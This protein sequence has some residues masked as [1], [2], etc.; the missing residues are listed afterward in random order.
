MSQSKAT[1][2]TID[3]RTARLLGSL[4]RSRPVDPGELVAIGGIEPELFRAF[5]REA[6]YENDPIATQI[7]RAAESASDES[8][9]SHARQAVFKRDSSDRVRLAAATEVAVATMAR[10]EFGREEEVAVVG[11]EEDQVASLW[12][13]LIPNI[14]VR[15]E[16]GREVVAAKED[17]ISY[18][19]TLFVGLGGTGAK[20][21]DALKTLFQQR[22]LRDLFFGFRVFDSDTNERDRMK[23]VDPISE[24]GLLQLPAVDEYIRS[25]RSVLKDWWDFSYTVPGGLDQGAMAVRPN[26][27]LCLFHNARNVVFNHLVTAATTIWSP[28]AGEAV[29]LKAQ[30]IVY[31]I[32]SLCGGMG[33][34]TFLDTALLVQEA[35]LQVTNRKPQ[36][37]GVF[38]LNDFYE[39][40]LAPRHWPALKRNTYAAL[41]ELEYFMLPSCPHVMEEQTIDY[42]GVEVQCRRPFDLIYLIQATSLGGVSITRMDQ[43]AYMLADGIFLHLATPLG[44]GQRS[45]FVNHARTRVVEWYRNKPC[46]F[47]SMG[48]GSLA[49][50]QAQI[51][52]YATCL[53]LKARSRLLMGEAK[54]TVKTDQRA[55]KLLEE[56]EITHA[57]IKDK[58]RKSPSGVPYAVDVA[59]SL[60]AQLGSAG[61]RKDWPQVIVSFEHGL[62]NVHAGL[63][64]QMA[65]QAEALQAAVIAKVKGETNAMFRKAEGAGAICRYLE[66][67]DHEDDGDE[68]IIA[69]Q[70]NVAESELETLTRRTREIMADIG[71][72]VKSWFG[73]RFKLPDLVEGYKSAVQDRVNKRIEVDY[74]AACRDFY[75]SFDRE[76][77]ELRNLLERTLL[78][79]LERI[80]SKAGKELKHCQAQLT[81]FEQIHPKRTNRTHVQL[82][83]PFGRLEKS[84]AEVVRAKATSEVTVAAFANQ[85][86]DIWAIADCSGVAERLMADAKQIGAEVV[87]PSAVEALRA[88]AAGPHACQD[89]IR[90][91]C[92]SVCPQWAYRVGEFND[93]HELTSI[94]VGKG[95]EELIGTYPVQPQVATTGNLSAIEVLKTEH[96]LPLC[97]LDGIDIMHREYDGVMNERMKKKGPIGVREPVHLFGDKAAQWGEPAVAVAEEDDEAILLFALGNAFSQMFPPT[98]EERKYLKESWRKNCIY[99]NQALHFLQPF[100]AETDISP[101][102]VKDPVILGNSRIKSY[103][104][105]ADKREYQDE[106]RKYWNERVARKDSHQVR[107]LLG[108]YLMGLK[109]HVGRAH[110]DE[111][112]DLLKKEFDRVAFYHESLQ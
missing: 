24:F 48:V 106:I 25:H 99:S 107:E 90:E 76:L 3:E 60:D 74:L 29:A 82:I 85:I 111:L 9:D 79:P 11:R 15:D 44:A 81:D 33:G 91:F 68:E 45:S 36:V 31:I 57:A 101:R 20:T 94:G 100:Y 58:F 92:A 26:G 2:I 87:H 63:R 43:L 37:I 75:R 12:D 32:S 14:K 102:S 19:P 78:R 73:S 34:G 49:Y 69:G 110:D 72:A 71:Q 35:F 59:P 93:T 38:V 54:S 62:L 6:G 13:D 50:P 8:H 103:R 17:V 16:G 18:T 84:I 56:A 55:A 27:R 67:I 108:E 89:T 21:V 98:E 53:F 112:K 95:N 77:A 46:C 1:G 52:R 22:A 65:Q 51:R 28:V 41:K 97:V 86:K 104:A 80:A 10:D 83:I 47:S 66:D 88:L 23:N 61:K 4:A 105:F 5:L 64:T 42:G 109:K 96:G 30:P 40:Q 39:K 70:V 7:L